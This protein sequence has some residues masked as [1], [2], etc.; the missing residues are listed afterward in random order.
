MHAKSPGP[1]NLEH[2]GY[3]PAHKA[4][5]PLLGKC[6]K[7]AL[8]FCSD[9]LAPDFL[10]S[11]DPANSKSAVESKLATPFKRCTTSKWTLAKHQAKD[12][13]ADIPRRLESA[14]YEARGSN[15]R[16]TDD[17][18]SKHSGS[19]STLVDSL[20][21]SSESSGVSAQ[22]LGQH[23]VSVPSRDQSWTRSN[24]AKTGADFSRLESR[25]PKLQEHSAHC[26][27]MPQQGI[28]AHRQFILQRHT[29]FPDVLEVIDCRSAAV[30][31][32]RI[33]QQGKL[34]CASFYRASQAAA[35]REPRNRL[36]A[37]TCGFLGPGAPG[38][39]VPSFQMGPFAHPGT[40]GSYMSAQIVSSSFGGNAPALSFVPS[41]F[42]SG[43]NLQ[44]RQQQYTWPPRHP[45]SFTRDQLWE[46]SSPQPGV[47][48]LHCRDT[49]G[50]LDPIPL[51]PMVLDRYQF[52][53]RFYLSGTKMR[54]Q[55]RKQGR[56]TVELQCF[57]RNRLAARLLFGGCSS[58]GAD[59]RQRL[60]R[61]KSPRSSDYP[62]ATHAECDAPSIIILPVAFS[63]L[64]NVDAA[65]VE[66]F[67]LFT[68]IE[69]FECFLH[70]A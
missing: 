70:S 38:Y 16:T 14:V 1:A 57:V 22:S 42:V 15:E 66:S 8:R 51:T 37:A 31:Y 59:G 52:C 62:P 30:E 56:S 61:N 46:I 43:T 5:D 26:A 17:S 48:P 10:R 34:W 29:Q 54:W 25:I 11:K 65:I 18:S 40:H 32:R 50:S 35:Q 60:W 23:T 20:I 49:R 4:P 41:S 12:H 9:I 6:K 33:V 21:A 55:A 63:R 3:L 13:I 2:F 47:F 58:A 36:A 39:N 7:T 19:R 68:G 67:V 69:V 64:P 53:Y 45:Y 28:A 44:Q 27:Y 24:V